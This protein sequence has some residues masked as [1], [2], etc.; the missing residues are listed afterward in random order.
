VWL[1]GLDHLKNPVTS[2]RVEPATFRLG[3][4]FLKQPSY[5]VPPP[6]PNLKVEDANTRCLVSD[7]SWGADGRVWRIGGMLIGKGKPFFGTPFYL[8]SVPV[9]SANCVDTRVHRHVEECSAALL[10]S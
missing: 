1:D 4:Q 9:H 7:V 2:S 6:S 10:R 8:Q 3:A 5:R